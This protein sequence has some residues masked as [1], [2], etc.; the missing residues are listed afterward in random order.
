MHIPTEAIGSI[1]R[2]AYLIE[3]YSKFHNRE[4]SAVELDTLA[5]QATI[6]TI[7]KLE[8]IGCEIITDGEQRKF[9]SFAGYCLHCAENISPDGI[10]IDFSDGHYRTLPT[11]NAGPFRYQYTAD[12][13]LAFAQAN[14]KALVKQAVISPSLISLIYPIQGLPDYSRT[15]FI[16]DLLQQHTAEIRKCLDLSAHKVQIDFTEARLSLKLDPSGELL[17]NM[18][19]L[20]NSALSAFTDEERH[21][22]GIHTCPGSDNDASHS[23]DVDYKYLLPTL[24][25]I[26][27]GNFYIAMAGEKDPI[28][29]LRLIQSCLRPGIRVFIGVI[30]PISP[31]IESP[32]LVCERVLQAAKYI[33]V[34]QLGICDDCGFAPFADDVSTSR[35]VVFSKIKSRLIGV[36][37]AEEKLAEL[38]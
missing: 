6:E 30:D 27:V 38:G 15:Q 4:I 28:S 32:E 23:A 29:A 9:N 35:E 1:P 22:I 24:F 25:T 14:S 31:E 13:F 16:Q 12:Q 33:P 37:L 10:R 36:R 11:L 34:D 19:D 18:V 3:A 21:R 8:A 5:K 17:Q 20:I 2:P 7:H 26:N